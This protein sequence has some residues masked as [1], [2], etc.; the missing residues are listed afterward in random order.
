MQI[1]GVKLES[2]YKIWKVP[3][4]LKW[5]KEL[6]VKKTDKAH[7]SQKNSI[8]KCQNPHCGRL[9]S[10]KEDDIPS[11]LERMIG[12]RYSNV[13]PWKCTNLHA[14]IPFSPCALLL[15][16][17]YLPF[18]TRTEITNSAQPVQCCG[19]S[20]IIIKSKFWKIK[21]SFHQPERVYK[22]L[23]LLQGEVF[24]I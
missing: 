6:H 15:L 7:K 1:R 11:C 2:H 19:A 12:T 5:R 22:C 16:H 10:V 3:H 13:S 9:L 8:K 24:F 21:L 23:I 4:Y 20:K 18:C 14:C 17:T